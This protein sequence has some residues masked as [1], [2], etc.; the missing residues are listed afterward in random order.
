MRDKNCLEVFLT[1]LVLFASRQKRT[2]S[3]SNLELARINLNLP[4]KKDGNFQPRIT[5]IS[6]KHS[7]KAKTDFFQKNHPQK[8]KSLMFG[9]RFHSNSERL[10]KCELKW[11]TK[12]LITKRRCSH[13]FSKSLVVV[14]MQQ[15]EIKNCLGI[16]LTF[17]VLFAS[18]QKRTRRILL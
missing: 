14:L 6:T 9:R 11:E 2:R 5:R 15:S 4:W 7:D 10:L 13:L 1:F 12:A 3:V 17:L 8:T 18:R 16:F